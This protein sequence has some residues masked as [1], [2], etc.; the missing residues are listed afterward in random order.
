MCSEDKNFIYSSW[1]NSF[2][3][4]GFAKNIEPSIYFANHQLVID[5]L[6]Q[7]AKVRVACMPETPEDIIGYVVYDIVGGIHCTHFTYVKNTF[8]RL[9]VAK[10][11][12]KDSGLDPRVASLYTHFT[13]VMA[14]IQYKLKMVYHPYL[15]INKD[16]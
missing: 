15:L 8:R 14:L 1:L 6:L 5:N 9:G 7:N 13:P 11:L 16:K 12:I 4:K 10:T 2:Q 3:H